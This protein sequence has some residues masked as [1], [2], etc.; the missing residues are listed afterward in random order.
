MK[1]IIITFYVLLL[2]TVLNAQNIY[3]K[4]M[5][6]TY[7]KQF[8]SLSYQLK[9]H[10]YNS[11]VVYNGTLYDMFVGP[12][13]TKKQARK[14]LYSINTNPNAELFIVSS[15]GTFQALHEPTAQEKNTQQ[16]LE[17]S[18]I[19]KDYFLALAIGMTKMDIATDNISGNMVLNSDIDDSGTTFGIEGGLYLNDAIFTT[20]NYHY[21]SLSDVNLNNIYM[22]LNYHFLRDYALSPY[23]GVLGG[24]SAL[25]W[26]TYPIDSIDSDS[27]GGA[28]MGGV[29]LGS[30]LRIN[31]TLS[32]YLN[33]QYILLNHETSLVNDTG[34]KK[35][36]HQSQNNL[37][38][39]IKVSF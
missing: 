18:H 3:V 1:N 31:Q 17:A 22:T 38:I 37:Y 2:T 10:G 24:Y 7:K 35:I 19:H 11:V 29:Q 20:L 30:D 32:L 16:K 36:T 25:S 27:L 5:S 6:A 9:N 26:S 28:F 14:A 34:E 4:A 21:Q 8:Y 13:Q 39:G 15:H 12:F 33:Y 23:I